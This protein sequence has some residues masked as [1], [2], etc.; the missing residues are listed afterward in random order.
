MK[1]AAWIVAEIHSRIWSFQLP[2]ATSCTGVAFTHLTSKT[3]SPCKSAASS[4]ARKPPKTTITRL[5]GC[6]VGLW[7]YGG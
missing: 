4:A 1:V 5:V 3:I 6:E 7:F 2:S